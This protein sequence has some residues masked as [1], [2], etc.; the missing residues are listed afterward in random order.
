MTIFRSEIEIFRRLSGFFHNF[1]CI[2]MN[3][4][5]T[6]LL[7][8]VFFSITLLNAQETFPQNGVADQRDGLYAFTNATIYKT[9]NQKLESATLVIKAGKVL[10]CGVGVSIPADAVII[11]CQNKTIYPSFI[12]IYTD[13]G[14]P[15]LEFNPSLGRR[16]KPQPLTDKEGAYMW[17]EAL[18]PEI[19]AYKDFT[20]DEKAAA[21]WRKLGFGVV[22][23]HQKDGIA[24]GAATLVALGD[25]REHEMILKETTASHFAFNKGKSSQNYPSS[26]MG[27]MAL[28]RQTYYDAEW[29]A[30]GGKNEEVNI[31]LESWNEQK[32]LPQIFDVS[33]W[34]EV[35]RA[36]KI[37]DQFNMQYI[38]KGGGDEYRRAREMKQ[39]G[40]AFILPLNFPK[41]YD[42]EDPFDALR[43][44][45]ADMKHWEMAPMNAKIMQEA[46][47]DFAF[48]LHGLKDKKA[49]YKNLKKAIKSGLSEEAALKALTY[50]P[51]NLVGAAKKVG[52]LEN[53]RYANFIITNGNIFGEKSKVLHNWVKGNPYVLSPIDA[54]DLS[55]RYKL[56]LDDDMAYPL[57]VRDEKMF[58][59][60]SDSNRIKVNYS[61][62][63]DLI[64]LSFTPNGKKGKVRLSGIIGKEWNG[65]GQDAAGKWID[66]SAKRS[67][68]LEEKMDKK[69]KK[70]DRPENA[71]AGKVSYPFMAYGWN[72]KPVAKKV[73][74]KNVTVWT[75]EVEGILEKTDV[76]IENGKI[77][78][79][80]QN[81]STGN[82]EEV[83]GSGKHLTCGVV[84]EHSHIAVSRGVNEG[85]QASSAEVS[86]EDVVNSED[87]NIYRQLAGGVTTSQLLH[88]SANPIGGQ[89][90]LIK[91]RWGSTPDEMLFKGADKFIKFALGENVKQTNWGDQQ[92]VRF[93]QTRMGVEQVFEDYFSRAADY[94]KMK[95]SGKFYRKDLDLETIVEILDSKRFITCHS[96][97]QSEINMLMKVAEKYGFRVNTFT[98][99]LEGY[100][101]A[102]KMAE[103]GVA[104]STFSDWWAYKYE[105][106]DAIPQNGAIMHKN[107]VLT[108]F[109]SDDAEMARRLNQEAAKAVKYGGVSEEDAWKF[110][111]LNPAK[112]LHIDN[113]VGSIKV[114][115]DADVVLW[116]DNPL[117]I[118]AKAEMTFVDGIK[119]FDRAEDLEK[120][121]EL[122]KERARLTQKMLGE[123]RKGGKTQ[124][125]K[126]KEQHLYHC[127]DF[128]DEGH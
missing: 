97:R 95:A 62:Q 23:S 41:A 125:V 4:I 96:Y 44:D 71:I 126:G 37:G 84:D 22:S 17:N 18:K 55:G 42:V 119:Y 124:A 107:G 82:A 106:I 70:K 51:A 53:G 80:G 91:L 31:S 113:R 77:A 123:K 86:I 118:Y 104:G 10:N 45:L 117:S 24:R 50:T 89:S 3:K 93:P 128:H 29:Y 13:Y 28:L 38:F 69:G 109:N 1:D 33:N 99:I 79:I 54:A 56:I 67:G 14:M 19:R 47:I 9:Y 27:M 73:L 85:T 122:R 78:K 94:K 74:F 66:W 8:F 35:L 15:E 61:V 108:G 43:A 20:I 21:E 6:T 32:N 7:T 65:R 92:K 60:Y 25:E 100:K 16:G 39:T 52:S 57:E 121:E 12:D 90:A 72:E 98:H 34:Q 87:V 40:G 103:H 81:L 120:R 88:G 116:S 64:S 63:D 127:D 75:N 111:T 58:I 11:D 114:G 101:V 49:F 2:S 76:L 48:T 115:K 105:V 46:G 110:V 68:D 26:L 112:M 36:D 102:D 30:N 5:I 83:D 59:S